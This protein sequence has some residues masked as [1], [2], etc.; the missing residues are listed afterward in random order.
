MK[1]NAL[2]LNLRVSFDILISRCILDILLLLSPSF[3]GTFLPQTIHLTYHLPSASGSQGR[4][5]R[6]Q[7]FLKCL[8]ECLPALLFPPEDGDRSIL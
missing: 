4:R 7:L 5:E 2:L 6:C 1:A 8:L 3:H